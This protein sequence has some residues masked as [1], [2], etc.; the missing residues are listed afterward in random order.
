MHACVVY[1]WYLFNHIYISFILIPSPLCLQDF[2]MRDWSD[3]LRKSEL[4]SHTPVLL[5]ELAVSQYSGNSSDG[6][7]PPTH[8]LSKGTSAL[9][10]VSSVSASWRGGNGK[11]ENH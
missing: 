6:S 10:K 9:V 1:M 3:K 4:Y 11:K 7:H 5:P 2:L 8:V